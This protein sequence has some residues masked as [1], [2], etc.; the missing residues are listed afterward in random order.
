M[1]ALRRSWA[2]AERPILG[3]NSALAHRAPLE[4]I[5]EL[6]LLFGRAIALVG[7]QHSVV[8]APSLRSNPFPVAERPIKRSS[9]LEAR[10]AGD[11]RYVGGGGRKQPLAQFLSRIRSARL[12]NGGPPGEARFPFHG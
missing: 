4:E 9:V 3:R 1:S 12:K 11:F 5:E 2:I 10:D 8:V 6:A 7:Q